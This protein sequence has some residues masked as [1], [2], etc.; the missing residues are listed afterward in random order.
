M[1][2]NGAPLCKGQKN[3]VDAVG[4]DEK[5][6]W[7]FVEQLV[8]A[9]KIMEMPFIVTV[10]VA[11]PGTNPAANLSPAATVSVCV[12]S[13]NA[14]VVDAVNDI[15]WLPSTPVFLVFNVL[16]VVIVLAVKRQ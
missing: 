16:A 7:N 3:V 10:L 11:A 4:V 5:P 8:F 6:P 2:K 13:S 12:V 1:P 14:P 15:V 9:S